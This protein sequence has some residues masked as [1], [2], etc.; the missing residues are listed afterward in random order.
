MITMTGKRII[1]EPLDIEK[2]AQ[3]YFLVSQ[4][5]KIHTYTGNLVPQSLSETEALLQKY[6][7]LFYNWMIL[8]REN[9][10][11]I[12]IIRLSKPHTENGTTT[13]GESQFLSSQYWRKGH[14]KEAKKLFYHYVFEELSLDTLY[15]D[16][17]DGNI[18]SM[19]SLESYGYRLIETRLELFSKTGE[20][21]PKHIYALSK[22]DYLS[23]CR[24]FRPVPHTN[25][26]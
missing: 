21:T 22:H 15:A 6:R 10:A 7:E 8:S 23:H 16:V 17:W 4:D 12:G 5:E 25:G 9:Q 20:Y 11:V 19:K 3:G 18:N 14:M 1:L 26:L 13:A 2:H 24:N